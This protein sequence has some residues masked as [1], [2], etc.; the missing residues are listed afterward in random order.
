MR[1]FKGPTIANANILDPDAIEEITKS[2]VTNPTL[3][4]MI[5]ME[6]RKTKNVPRKVFPC[7]PI[8][9]GDDDG[10]KE[11]SLLI[12]LTQSSGT[13]FFFSYVNIPVSDVGTV[14]RFWDMP[15]ADIL[16]D[17]DPLPDAPEIPKPEEG[18]P[19]Q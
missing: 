15:P 6:T 8:A 2:N 1:T 16:M 14:C 11:D 3:E 12:A 19:E 4:L 5:F 18:V 9:R 7:Y 17:Q 10:K 13:R